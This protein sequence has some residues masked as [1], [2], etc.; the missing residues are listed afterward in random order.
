[1]AG[2]EQEAQ[3]FDQEPFADDSHEHLRNVVRMEIDLWWATH[4][5]EKLGRGA[6][7]VPATEQCA[8]RSGFG[9]GV[10]CAVHLHT[11]EGMPALRETLEACTTEDLSPLA[12][13][14]WR[15]NLADDWVP[16]AVFS[17]ALGPL[18]RRLPTGG[19]FGDNPR[20]LVT[21]GGRT[22]EVALPAE[23]PPL[24]APDPI[25]E[26]EEEYLALAREAWRAAKADCEAA[27]W[28]SA[29][30]RKH[31]GAEFDYLVTAE[32]AI[33]SFSWAKLAA[34]HKTNPSRVRGAVSRTA[35][36]IGLTLPSE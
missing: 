5:F 28:P 34:Y 27:G 6:V 30:N 17:G 33:F 10:V 35:R 3:N 36:F 13:W 21:W 2:A 24:R 20:G 31:T 18:L 15:L 12:N 22:F 8:A 1:M 11:P 16:G 19:I 23:R 14:C 25:T 9:W 26:T 7:G 32:R 29:A 4:P